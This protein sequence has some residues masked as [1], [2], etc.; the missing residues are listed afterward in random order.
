M[1]RINFW[2]ESF[3]YGCTHWFRNVWKLMK[4]KM[5]IWHEIYFP[6]MTEHADTQIREKNK[7]KKN[8]WFNKQN[9]ICRKNISR[10]FQNSTLD[11]MFAFF[12]IL[13]WCSSILKLIE[14]KEKKN[15]MKKKV[16]KRWRE[17]E[18]ERNEQKKNSQN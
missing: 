5:K 6:S 4:K 18:Q 10:T 16:T 12:S 7:N 11:F 1:F 14:S 8:Q 3:K 2:M 15:E 9:E 17:I 13:L